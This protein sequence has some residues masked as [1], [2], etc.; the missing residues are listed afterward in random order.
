MREF[1]L[2]MLEIRNKQYL[3]MRFEN[4]NKYG[5]VYR[6]IRSSQHR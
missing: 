2:F 6:I 4:N 3:V 1:K 5:V